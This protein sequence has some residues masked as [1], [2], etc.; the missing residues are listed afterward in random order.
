MKLLMDKISSIN[1]YWFSLNRADKKENFGDLLSLYIVKNLTDRKIKF[2]KHPSMRRY[3]YLIKHYL[4]IGSILEVANKNSIVWGSGII[5]RHDFI[6]K[7]KFLAVRGPITKK[8]LEELGYS[9]P[10]YLGDPS[11]LLSNIYKSKPK[12]PK[13]EIGVIPHYVDYEEINNKFKNN[14]K[15]KI[16]D[17]ITANIETT[18]DE[19]CSCKYIVSSSLHGLIVPH[20]YG[21]PA[22][23]VKFS[24]KLGGDNIKFY[25]YFESVNLNYSKE[26]SINNCD[27]SELFFELLQ[28]N[29]EVILPTQEKINELKAGLLKSNP[30]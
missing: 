1:L 14:K 12:F 16:I 9:V 17:L 21:I 8:R 24:N 23:W 6:E 22:L 10:N 27:S 2:V 26:I 28:E 4:T 18:I 3:K 20:T 15:L 25:D 5:R 11:I 29:K 30:F 19:I 13:Y 7:A